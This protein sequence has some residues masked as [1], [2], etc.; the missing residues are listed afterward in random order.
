APR[1]P[2][3]TSAGRGTSRP[4]ATR[5]R[6]GPRPRRSR[7]GRRSGPPWSTP[8][9]ARRALASSE[10]PSGGAARLPGHDGIG[11]VGGE[12]VDE[13]RRRAGA[14]GAVLV[15][16]AAVGHRRRPAALG[17]HPGQAAQLR[18]VGHPRRPALERHV[19]AGDGHAERAARVALDVADLARPGPAAEVVPIV[20]PE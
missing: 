10:A 9:P 13:P 14:G 17:E 19:V 3:P 12:L 4:P 18:L 15:G 5:T 7:E 11:V 8:P 2:A 16:E 1:A 20:D 6:S